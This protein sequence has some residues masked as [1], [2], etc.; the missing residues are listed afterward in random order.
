LNEHRWIIHKEKFSVQEDKLGYPEFV[1]NGS[2]VEIQRILSRVLDIGVILVGLEPRLL[3]VMNIVDDEDEV[4]TEE[5]EE[6]KE[7]RKHICFEQEYTNDDYKEM[8][9]EM[10]KMSLEMTDMTKMATKLHMNVDDMMEKQMEDVGML[11]VEAETA[12][13]FVE[14]V[15]VEDERTDLTNDG[16]DIELDI[17]ENTFYFLE[18]DVEKITEEEENDKK[19][20]LTDTEERKDDE[21]DILIDEKEFEMDVLR[22]N[23]YDGLNDNEVEIMDSKEY[24]KQEFHVRLCHDEMRMSMIVAAEES[25]QIGLQVINLDG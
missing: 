13:N 10:Y 23:E 24:K 12:S 15:T 1:W 14:D 6:Q 5:E 7:V 8:L 22:T 16:D 25:A 11:T 21:K 17:D 9:R 18:E 19:N 2:T 3:K 4:V 20:I